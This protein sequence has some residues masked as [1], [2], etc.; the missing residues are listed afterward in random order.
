MNSI[1]NVDIEGKISDFL[2]EKFKIDKSRKHKVLFMDAR[3]LFLPER[4]D[5]IAKYKYI[6][7]VDKKIKTD[8]FYN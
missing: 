7:S 6:E 4:I 3:K 2:V 5:L 8:F 1:D